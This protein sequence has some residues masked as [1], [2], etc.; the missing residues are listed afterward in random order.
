MP[1]DEISALRL[2]MGQVDEESAPDLFTTPGDTFTKDSSRGTIR[3]QPA[4]ALQAKYQAP[5]TG[6]PL[7]G[8]VGVPSPMLLLPRNHPHSM[9]RAH[10]YSNVMNTAHHQPTYRRHE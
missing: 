9:M 10:M 1:S 3:V 8:V 5:R 7:S 2:R 6:R 4:L